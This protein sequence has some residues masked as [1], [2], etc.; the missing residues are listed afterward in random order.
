MILNNYLDF[1]QN[2]LKENLELLNKKSPDTCSLLKNVVP[3]RQYNIF[4]SKSGALTL[5]TICSDGISRLLHSKYDPIEEAT[6][7]IDSCF[8]NENSNYILSG[9]GLGYHLNELVRKASKNA[10]IVV[11]EKNLSLAR[12]AFT[13]NDFSSIIKH[14]G[15]SFHIGVDPDKLEKILNDDRTNLAI[16]GYTTVNFKPL[17]ELEI[18]YYA[19][20]KK[21]LIQTL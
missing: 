16:Y 4:P 19:S 17:I 14:P 9:L 15:I 10:R 1:M 18:N 12:L 3:E 20:I 8:S 7:F 21:E 5:S 6:R 13:H 2:F 11:I